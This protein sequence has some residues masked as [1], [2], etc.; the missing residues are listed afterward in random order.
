[1]VLPCPVTEPDAVLS[2]AS[3]QPSPSA[4]ATAVADV[5]IG[6]VANPN[7]RMKCVLTAPPAARLTVLPPDA[8][9]DDPDT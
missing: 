8:G 7:M 3:T 4:C 9:D 1:V 2:S 6:T 5:L